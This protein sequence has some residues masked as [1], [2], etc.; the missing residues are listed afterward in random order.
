M[1]NTHEIL[2]EPEIVLIT[3]PA[4]L[5]AAAFNKK[6]FSGQLA[7]ASIQEQTLVKRQWM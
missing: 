3:V 6:M 5:M 4:P 1:N 7:A 2:E